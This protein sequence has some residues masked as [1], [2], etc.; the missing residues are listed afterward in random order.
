[1]LTR[2]FAFIQSKSNLFFQPK[3]SITKNPCYLQEG[4]NPTNK[5]KASIFINAKSNDPRKLISVLTEI[6]LKRVTFFNSI[7]IFADQEIGFINYMSSIYPLKR[8]DTN[9]R[10]ILNFYHFPPNLTNHLILL[11]DDDV[12]INGQSFNNVLER[13]IIKLDFHKDQFPQIFTPFVRKI[14]NNKYEID[15]QDGYNAISTKFALV[16][17]KFLQ[18]YNSMSK[19]APK[20]LLNQLE[21]KCE[22]IWFN[23]LANKY[24]KNQIN[25]IE[26]KGISL[27]ST[28]ESL[29][30]NE[31]ET[32]ISAIHEFFK[33]FQWEDYI[34][35]KDYFKIA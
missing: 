3:Q 19:I 17:Y 32:C 33:D 23:F 22:D 9:Q 27:N 20:T 1:M 11:I 24:Y 6:D 28:E 8:I 21:G 29:H 25:K 12:I 34:Q 31:K 4:I 2:M 14:S 13:M 15:P 16:N 10:N 18:L 7:Y 5:L 30:I 26:L 35:N